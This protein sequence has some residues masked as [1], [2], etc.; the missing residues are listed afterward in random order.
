MMNADDHGN[1]DVRKRVAHVVQSGAEVTLKSQLLGQDSIQIIHDVVEDDQH[2]EISDTI[3]K[4]K[5]TE[6]QHTKY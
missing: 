2:T 5:N 4:K 6:R 3:V 1:K